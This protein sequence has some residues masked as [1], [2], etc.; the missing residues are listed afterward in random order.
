MIDPAVQSELKKF[1]EYWGPYL[2]VSPA[3]ALDRSWLSVGVIDALTFALRKRPDLGEFERGVLRG[4]AAYLG[5]LAYDCWGAFGVDARVEIAETG[6]VIKGASGPGIGTEEEVVAHVE[7]DLRHV[8]ET[9]PVELAVTSSFSRVLSEVDNFVSPF[10]FGLFTGTIPSIEGP[11]EHQTPED[12]GEHIEKVVKHLAQTCAD[13]Y[14]TLYPDEP[15]GQVAELY[16]RQLIYPLTLMAEDLPLR[17]AVRGMIEFF[18]EYKVSSAMRLR[19]AYHLSGLPDERI[20][21]AGFVF[22]VALSDSVMS[23]EVRA[24]AQQLGLTVS[25]YRQA[26]LDVREHYGLSGDWLLKPE[27]SEQD[28]NQ[29][30][31][32]LRLG[33]FP[34]LKMSKE[35]VLASAGDIEMQRLLVHLSQFNMKQAVLVLDSLIDLTPDDMQ[36]RLQRVYFEVVSGEM[37]AAEAALKSLM[38]EPESENQ[39]Q[40]F[41]LMGMLQLIKGDLERAELFL[42]KAYGLA[43]ADDIVRSELANNYAWLNLLKGDTEKALYLLEDSLA[44]NPGYFT[45]LLNQ[46]TAL[47]QQGN[48]AEAAAMDAELIRLAPLHRDVFRGLIYDPASA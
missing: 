13:S 20:A 48:E 37:E 26:M 31:K 16:L 12:F 41:D 19:L 5:V 43:V 29:I 32:E 35:R 42:K 40:I 2:Q 22:F 38:S 8:L 10:A 28:A 17:Q 33:F 34:W 44:K 4:A 14:A 23:P 18:E 6:V 11:W 39:P 47:H 27:Y 3:L 9:L 7:R 30:T 1:E 24:R 25:L 46:T 15:L 21:G 45:A 36:L